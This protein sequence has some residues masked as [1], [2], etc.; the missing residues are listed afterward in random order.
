[1]EK[2]KFYNTPILSFTSFEV[3]DVLNVSEGSEV[4]GFDNAGGWGS[5][6]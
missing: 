4:F 3:K 1:M 5:Q 2:R 6:W